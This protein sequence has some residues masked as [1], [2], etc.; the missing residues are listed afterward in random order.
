[1]LKIM[2]LPPDMS[3]SGLIIPAQIR[4]LSP[5]KDLDHPVGTGDL[6]GVWKALGPKTAF[7]TAL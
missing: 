6:S 7:S 2:R 3:Y 1:M 4:I 5:L